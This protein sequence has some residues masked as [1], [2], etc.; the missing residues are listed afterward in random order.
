MKKL[1][2]KVVRKVGKI[3]VMSTEF[4]CVTKI[5]PKKWRGWFYDVIS[6]DAP[7]S[8]G[9]NNRTMITAARF[10]DHCEECIEPEDGVPTIKEKEKF[11]AMLRDLGQMYVDLEN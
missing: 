11:I 1:N 2:T 3:P 10:A 6:T 4:V 7:F 8:W 5:V 9:D